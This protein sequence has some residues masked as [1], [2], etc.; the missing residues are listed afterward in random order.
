MSYFEEQKIMFSSD[1]MIAVLLEL[2]LAAHILPQI[3]S[4]SCKL[5]SALYAKY[6]NLEDVLCGLGNQFLLPKDS[7]ITVNADYRM[8]G[9]PIQEP[10]LMYKMTQILFHEAS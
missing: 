2:A 6:V 3:T 9:I 4:T 1:M 5:L 8:L 10:C 7:L